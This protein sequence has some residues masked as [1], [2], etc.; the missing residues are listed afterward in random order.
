MQV[1]IFSVQHLRTVNNNFDLFKQLISACSFTQL[2]SYFHRPWAHKD[3][4]IIVKSK[5][6]CHRFFFHKKIEFQPAARLT[7]AEL[8][9]LGQIRQF[10]GESGRVLRIGTTV[11]YKLQ[12]SVTWRLAS[13]LNEGSYLKVP[14]I[15]FIPIYISININSTV[16]LLSCAQ[17]SRE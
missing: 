2:T 7:T 9:E 15:G 14:N 6:T 12:H 8:H 1:T 13:Y 5:Q 10:Q 11:H 4:Q 16:N 17:N 3:G